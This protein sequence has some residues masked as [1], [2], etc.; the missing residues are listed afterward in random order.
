[1]TLDR[2]S[3][4]EL[5]AALVTGVRPLSRVDSQVHGEVVLE[6][7]RAL[8]QVTCERPVAAGV[9][10][11][12]VLGQHLVEG[13]P[14]PAQLAPPLH[15]VQVRGQ[16]ALVLGEDGELGPADGAGVGLGGVLL[17]LGRHA[18]AVH[19]PLLD[20]LLDVRRDVAL[21]RNVALQATPTQ[22]APEG[23]ALGVATHVRVV[24]DELQEHFAADLRKK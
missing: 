6:G 24:Q 21:V 14:L 5:L 10:V 17:L 12:L 2:T 13:K 16:V 15:L 8:A 9:G 11:G 3:R 4:L 1:M 7:E 19:L 23:R 18:A 20:V 22:L